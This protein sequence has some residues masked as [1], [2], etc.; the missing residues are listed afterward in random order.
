[1]RN[2]VTLVGM[3]TALFAGCSVHPL[4]DDV[5]R[6]DTVAIVK[7]IRCEAQSK[8]HEKILEKLQN[9]ES[10]RV[11]RMGAESAISN[12]RKVRQIDL[13]T[14][15]AIDQL[16]LN[17]IAYNFEFDITEDND[18]SGEANFRLP[19]TAGVFNIGVKG[20]LKQK[21]NAKREFRAVDS[22]EQ[23]IGL[24][25]SDFTKQ[26]KLIIYPLT[27]SVGMA[28][29]VGTFIELSEMGGLGTLA[30]QKS[31]FSDTLTFT[32]TVNADVTADVARTPVQD[33]FRLLDA[34]ANLGATRTDVH[35]VIITM[36]PAS[37]DGAN[38]IF[39]A[40]TRAQRAGII[41]QTKQRVVEE[42]CIQEA[43]AREDSAQQLRFIAPELYCYESFENTFR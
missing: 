18:N 35:K 39:G 11:K 34:K 19:F 41:L 3:V 4:P 22:F 37:T 21:R 5:S 30:D 29:I 31:L 13:Q 1:M 2:N 26:P 27:G 14:A 25:C 20:G 12:L 16:S 15:A 42:L 43:E 7:N 6:Q 17:S 33:K 9:S 38:V 24:D 40:L 8:I 28:E 36:S 10:K 23:L 32:T